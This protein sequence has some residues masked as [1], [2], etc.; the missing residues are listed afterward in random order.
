MGGLG[1]AQLAKRYRA[2]GNTNVDDRRYPEARHELLNET[3][4]KDVW[5]DIVSWIHKQG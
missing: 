5:S 3:N 4:R 2:A 1:H